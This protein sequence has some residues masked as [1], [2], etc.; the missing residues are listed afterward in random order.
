[1]P[2]LDIVKINTPKED[3][4]Y[5]PTQQV[6]IFGPALH[7]LLNNMLETMRA[8]QGVGLAAPQV[9][10]SQRI[11][12]IEYPD[13]EED[14]ENTM[15]VYELI[16]P[17]ILKARGAEVEQEGCLSIPNIHGDVTRPESISIRYLDPEFN[18]HTETYTGMNA[19]VIQHEY[20]HIEGIL[21]T[22]KLKP[23]KR[24]R[25]AKKLDKIKKGIVDCD[26]KVKR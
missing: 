19:R 11:T 15:R 14:P 18:L 25:L 7:M 17:K 5:K 13:D 22:E 26:Y 12:V 2:L 21:F 4:L 1:M 6:R 8:S 3:I 9:G 20:D 16:N 24:A 23:L 10:I